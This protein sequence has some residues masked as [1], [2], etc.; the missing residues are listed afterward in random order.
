MKLHTSIIAVAAIVGLAAC[1]KP[2]SEEKTMS[3]NKEMGSSQ[4]SSMSN[5]DAEASKALMRHVYV[6]IFSKHQWDSLGNYVTTD[7]VDYN[8]EPGQKPGLEGMKEA[9]KNFNTSFPDLTFE[10]KTVTKD[11]D[12][13][14]VYSKLKG[15]WKGD[16]MGMKPNGKNFEI[17]QFD[18]VRLNKENKAVE[19][20]G[21]SDMMAMM[22]QLGIMPPAPPAK[23]S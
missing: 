8:P 14:T 22:T 4:T 16:F 13:Y 19:R 7:F 12:W 2:A 15:T 11:G 3:D 1:N 20:R 23:K 18:M 17:D 6:D 9:F 10:P 21:M 5:A